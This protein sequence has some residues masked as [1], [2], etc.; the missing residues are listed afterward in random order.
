MSSSFTAVENPLI[1][2]SLAARDSSYRSALWA[3]AAF[4][5]GVAL[6]AFFEWAAMGSATLL[7]ELLVLIE[8]SAIYSR[9]AL[10]PRLNPHT[11]A[12]TQFLMGAGFGS[13]AVLTILN[14]LTRILDE[15]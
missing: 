6:A 7:S 12:S 5:S 2:A 11:D 4:T 1:S 15:L 3:A 9:A 13:L 14:S 8:S 10:A